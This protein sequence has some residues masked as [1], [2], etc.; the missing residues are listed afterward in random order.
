MY[1]PQSLQPLSA[2][3]P[4]G[5]I[6]KGNLCAEWLIVFNSTFM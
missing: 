6:M 4:L 3:M 1:G 5:L 2:N